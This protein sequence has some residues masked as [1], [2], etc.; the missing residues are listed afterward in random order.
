M[1]EMEWFIKASKP[2]QGMQLN[3]VSEILKV[4]DY[5]S[6]VLTRAFAEITGIKVNHDLMDEGLLVD[7]IEVEMQSGRPIYDFWMNDSD[8]IGTHPRYDDI[9][10]GS[11]TDFMQKNGKDVTSPTLDLPDFMGLSFGTFTDGKLYQLPDQQFANL[12]WFRHDWFQRPE[13]KAAFK[14]QF[15]YELGVPVNWSAYEDIAEFFTNTVKE[16]SMASAST[17]TWTTARRTPRSA[18]ASP[19]PGCPWPAPATAGLP[20]GK[21]VDEWG[22]R[23]EDGIPRGS[24]ITRGGD[25]NGPAAVYA[26]TKYVEWLK[27]YAPPEAAGM[28]FL[29]AGPVPAQGH[30][31]Q[32]IFWY[33]A[34][35]D[36]LSKPGL[37]VMN[38][39][40][41][42]KWR[43]APSPHGPY[44]KDGM[45]LGY[46]DVGCWTM[47]K[48]RAHGKNQGR[49][50]VCPVLHVQDRHAEEG[51][52]VAAPDPRERRLARRHDRACAKGR[53]PSG[54]LPQ[55]S[56]QAVDAHWRERP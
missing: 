7:K 47:L 21:P 46:Q 12:Y 56:P 53:R 30:I 44:W 32:Q 11:L 33:S 39:D 3:T 13:L 49:L 41:T 50:A 37:P 24:S 55:P 19:T 43:M 35:T 17:A 18:G 45:K 9:V 40:G 26:L 5:E 52:G 1:A 38:A 23:M 36:S 42:P 34:F 51:A 6:K 16:R 8:F 2:F 10:D 25:A 31:A 29:E 15:G 27:K 28:D 22:I 48:Y 20:N 4:H 54:V 14:K